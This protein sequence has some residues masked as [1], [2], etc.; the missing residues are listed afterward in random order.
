MGELAE[1]LEVSGSTVRRDLEQ[2]EQSGLIR[3]THGGVFWT[4]EPEHMP[5]FETRGN[6]Q[7]PAKRA[8]AKA[9]AALVNDHETILLDGGS[10]TY[11]IARELFG[12]PLQVVTNSLP[13]AYL[14]STSDETDLVLIGGWVHGPTAVAIG[15]PADA[16]LANINVRK[17]FVSVAGITE[18]GYFNRDLM[19]VENEK[20][21]LAAADESI[22]VADSSKFGHVSL[23][24]LCGLQEVDRVVTD[25]AIDSQWKQ[26]IE[27]A[28]VQLTLAEI[29]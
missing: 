21:M 13:V 17:A 1:A 25:G 28:C 16:M 27:S 4:G 3:R 5:V 12:R 14:L 2:L 11:E 8:I 7:W 20:A 19:L 29:D 23:S 26:W 9:A 24:R 10:T 6:D 18:Q 22:I 15:P